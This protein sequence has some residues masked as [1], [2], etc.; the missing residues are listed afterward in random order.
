MKYFYKYE[1][2]D[3]EYKLLSDKKL[4]KEEVVE[5]TLDYKYIAEFYADIDKFLDERVK[6]FE[7][8]DLIKSLFLVETTITGYDTYDSAVYCAYNEDEVKDFIEKDMGKD[9]LDSKISKIGIALEDV[10]LGQ[11]VASFN[12]G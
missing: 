11:I 8:S 4:N 6:N 5:L 2:D 9:Y 12:A 3:N 10:E 7:E 1:I